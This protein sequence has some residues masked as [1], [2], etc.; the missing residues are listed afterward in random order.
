MNQKALFLDRDGVINVDKGYI[1]KIKDVEFI[2][3]IFALIKKAKDKDYLVIIIT[4]QS[5]VGRGFFSETNLS[6]VNNWILKKLKMK[7]AIVDDLFYCTSPPLSEKNKSSKEDYRRKPNPG[8]ILE[9]ANKYEINLHDSIMVGDKVSDIEVEETLNKKIIFIQRRYFYKNII[10]ISHLN[11]I[12][13][14]L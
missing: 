8:M 2:E 1:C 6:E 9:A 5:G 7:G 12:E 11:K 10:S 4:N 13:K 3:G 14:Y